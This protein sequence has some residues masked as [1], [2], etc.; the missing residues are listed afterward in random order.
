MIRPQNNIAGLSVLLVD[1]EP[2]NLAI[3]ESGLQ[4]MGMVVFKAQ[5]GAEALEIFRREFPDMVLM[6][7][8]MPGM[9][10]LEATRQIKRLCGERWVPV[11]MVTSLYSGADVVG[12]LEAGADDYLVKPVNF[13]ILRSKIANIALVIRQQQAL[14]KYHDDTEAEHEFA[15]E[16][17]EKLIR[18]T[19][20]GEWLHCWSMPTNRFNGDVIV[21]G[22]TP[23]GRIQVLLADATGH[24]LAAALNVIPVIEVFY[25][26]NDKGLPIEEIARELNSKLH[27]IM[28]TDRFV[29]AVILS[30]DRNAGEIRAWNGGIP[31]AAF[32]GAGGAVLHEWRSINP[33]LGLL[34]EAR[35]ESATEVFRC[36]REGFFFACSDGLLEAEDAAGK[37]VGRERLLGWLQADAPDKITHIAEQLFLHLRAPAHDDVSFL[38]APYRPADHLDQKANSL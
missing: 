3:L 24:G 21:A 32:I 8:L 12:G 17:M 25:G 4:A 30:I 36:D 27:K 26:M 7:V 14:R 38:V 16:V 20:F 34:D 11:V 22:D 33:P 37:P 19:D 15:V 9:D 13:Q 31:Y 18:P 23:D 29:A 1:D 35:F 5:S 10:G 2:I 6:D 28:P